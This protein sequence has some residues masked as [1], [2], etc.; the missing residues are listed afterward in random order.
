MRKTN[1]TGMN[2]FIGGEYIKHKKYYTFTECGGK[3]KNILK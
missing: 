2:I 1:E 3:F